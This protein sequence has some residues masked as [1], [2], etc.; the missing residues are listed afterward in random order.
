MSGT[1]AGPT[2]PADVLLRDI[3]RWDLLALMINATIGAGIFGLPSRVFALIGP[4]SLPA[5]VACAALVAMVVVCFA[6]VSSRFERT[7]GPYLYARVAFGPWVGFGI[8]WLQWLARLTA[9]AALSNL[10]ASY[11]AVFWPGAATEPGRVLVIVAVTVFL[12]AIN[13]AGVRVMAVAGNLFTVGKLIPILV[14]LVFGL[15]A[16]APERLAPGPPPPPADFAKAMLLLVFA[17]TGFEM[18][19]IPGGEVRD[20]RRNLPWAM[21]GGLAVVAVV[22]VLLQVVCMSAV[23]GLADSPR[24]LTDAAARVIGPVGAALVGAGALVSITGALSVTMLTAPRLL[25]AMAEWG[26]LPR[27]LGATHPRFRTPWVAI[28]VTSAAMLA[29]SLFS[30]FI[31]AL[32]ISTVIKLLSYVATC[33]ALPL[34][35][36]RGDVP[37]ATFRVPAGGGVALLALIA[38]GWLLTTVTGQEARVVA[39]ATMAGFTLFAARRAL[40]AAGA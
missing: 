11:L 27:E 34:L 12:T 10:L 2:A 5:F 24:P 38:C 9:F 33:L 13:L 1:P 29:L 31:G 30:T 3:R 25:F 35:R 4:W 28:L 15:A 36:R 21:L 22:Y 37:G 23:P 26:E 6:E 17:F 40:A 8:G 16:L 18:V 14:L 20:P 7:G 39:L 19:M 32:T